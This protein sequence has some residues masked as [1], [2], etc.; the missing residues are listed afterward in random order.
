MDLKNNKIK[1]GE[2]LKNE[3]ARQ[4]LKSSFPEWMDSPLL[5]MA[6]HMPLCEILRLAQKQVPQDKIQSVLDKLGQL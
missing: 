3:Q 6:K 4:V 1:L 5:Q 2:L